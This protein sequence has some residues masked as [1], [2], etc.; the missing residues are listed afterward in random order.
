MFTDD[1]EKE[2]S[3]KYLNQGYLIGD[4]KEIESFDFIR[5]F[6]I[7]TIKQFPN[8]KDSNISNTDI[9][10]QTH[11]VISIKDLNDFRIEIIK[12]LYDN[13]DIKFHY[14]NI[15]KD[16]LELIVGN[17]LA[18]QRRISVSIQLPNDNSSL[19]NVHADTWSGDSSYESVVWLPLVNCYDTKSMF[20]LSPDKNYIVNNLFEKYKNLSSSKIYE[21]IEKYVTW[22]KVDQGQ[23]LIFNQNLPHGNIVNVENETRWSLNCR[24]KGLFTPYAQKKLGEFFEPITLKSAS[25]HGMH[26]KLPGEK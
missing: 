24:F 12:K 19:L 13:S 21:E 14:Y 26:Y 15:A 20:I 10:N 2:L 11:K 3:Q 1:N 6:F 7:E 25:M 16:F 4:I 17:E 8:F 5:N 22:L 18:M 9:L 23:F